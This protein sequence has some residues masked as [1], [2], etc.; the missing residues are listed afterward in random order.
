VI[1]S[2]L[3]LTTG[4]VAQN[5]T[6]RLGHFY[7]MLSNGTTT[8]CLNGYGAW[9]EGHCG[10]FGVETASK[11]GFSVVITWTWLNGRRT[12]DVTEQNPALIRSTPCLLLRYPTAK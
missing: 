8:G 4:S 10:E 6:G 11:P 3:M 9:F 2:F 5:V 7:P 12:D 1:F